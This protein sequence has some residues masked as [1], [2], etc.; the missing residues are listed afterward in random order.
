MR[1]WATV[2]SLSLFFLLRATISVAQTDLSGA[3]TRC[4]AVSAPS[5]R[6]ACYDSLAK[7]LSVSKPTPVGAGAWQV[8]DETNPVDDTRTVVLRLVA[9]SGQSVYGKPI[10]LVLRCQSHKTEAYMSWGSYLGDE[11]Q[12]TVRVGSGE[13]KTKRWDVSTDHTG[14]FYHGDMVAFIRELVAADRFVAQVTPYNESPITA[15]FELTGLPTA[16]KPLRE[17]CGW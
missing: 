7:S 4:G 9:T 16:V 14:T 15:V 8:S 12:V 5:E 11:A 3:L 2:L 1:R 13:A 17:D 6:L 10:V